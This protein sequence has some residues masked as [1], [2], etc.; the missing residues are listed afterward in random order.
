M[1]E[2]I[3]TKKADESIETATPQSREPQPVLA[4]A[5]RPGWRDPDEGTLGEAD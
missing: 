2:N 3:P 1:T 5:K 4:D